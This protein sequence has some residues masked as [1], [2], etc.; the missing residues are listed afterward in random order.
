MS[1]MNFHPKRRLAVLISGNGSNL[2]A[3]LNACSA[4]QLPA[5]VVVVVSNRP[6]AFGLER[7]RQAGVPAVV[8]PKLPGQSRQE[9][10]A[11][12]AAL[13]QPYQ[14]DLVILAGWMRILTAAFLDVFSGRVINIHPALP[15]M[16]PG[17]HAIERAL[18]AYHAG[19]IRE[20][21]VMVHYVPDEGIDCGPVIAHRSVPILAG[22]TIETLTDRVH[23]TEHKLLVEAIASVLQL[24]VP[25]S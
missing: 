18:D 11:E 14:P 20:T 3:V 10:D 24:A 25:P 22:D 2:Q 23:Q 4:G 9:Y 19:E 15:G 1:N 21:G 8:K 12:L 7:A 16:F 6:E 5:E 17:T 13:V